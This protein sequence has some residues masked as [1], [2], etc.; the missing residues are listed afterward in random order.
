KTG[1]QILG[2]DWLLEYNTGQI[3][4]VTIESPNYNLLLHS[5]EEH[6]EFLHFLAS[7][8]TTHTAIKNGLWSDP[9]TWDKG[10]VPGSNANVLIP[11]QYK[12]I[13]DSENSVSLMTT[14]VDGALEFAADKNTKM[15][16]DTLAV[17]PTGQLTIGTASNPIQADKTAIIDFRSDT[18]ID[19]NS[20][21]DPTQL[22]KGL[23]SHGQVNIYGADKL[24]Y[25]K[26]QGN[27]L[28]G[29]QEL[30]LDLP[31]GMTTPSG[32]KVGDQLVLGGTYYDRKGADGKN[33]RFHDE[34]LTIIAIDGNR[35]RCKN[36]DIQS[37]NDQVLRFDH[38][39]TPDLSSQYN[40]KLYVANTTRNVRFESE[41]GPQTAIQR[42]GHVMLMHNPNVVVANAGFYNLGRTDKTKLIDDVEMNRD[43][44]PGGGTNIRGRYA[45]HF[46]KAGTDQNHAPIIASG[47]AIVG[48]PG[49]GISQ[50]DSNAILENNV[51]FDVAGA[52]YVAE[53]GTE[54][55]Q[56]K[57]NLAIKIT[58]QPNDPG[59]S[60]VD[61]DRAQR[62]DYGY[63]GDGYWVG[64]AGVGLNLSNNIA[65]S[66]FGA[67]LQQLNS[68]FSGTGDSDYFPVANL[69]EDLKFLGNYGYS[70][71][72]L[73]SLPMR[74]SGFEASNFRVGLSFYSL[75]ANAD[76]QVAMNE[77]FSSPASDVRSSITNFK[78][79]NIFHRGIEPFYSTR[80]DFVNGLVAANLAQ[81]SFPALSGISGNSDSL[82]HL[83]KNLRVEGFLTGIK[84]PRE[85]QKLAPISV[86][87]LGTRLEDSYL[88]NY[89]QNLFEGKEVQGGYDFSDYFK[90]SNTVFVSA[91]SNLA[92]T[93]AFTVKS[94]GS[95]AMSF[96]ASSSFDPDFWSR[97]YSQSGISP[98]SIAS[99][100]WDWN[101]DG[102]ID[103]FGRNVT[104]YFDTPGVSPVTLTVWD[105]YGKTGKITQNVNITPTAYSNL[106]VNG[107]FSL[108]TDFIRRSSQLFAQNGNLEVFSSAS[109]NYGWT[110]DSSWVRS[111]GAAVLVS[112]GNNYEQVNLQGGQRI[113]QVLAD[114]GIRRGQQTFSVDIKNIEGNAISNQINLRVWGING[115]FGWNNSGP[116]QYDA[117]PMSSTKLLDQTV[118]GSTFDWK[119]FS[120]NA[121]FGNGYQ[122][123]LVEVVPQ[124]V[125]PLSGDY[126][127]L[128]NFQ[129]LGT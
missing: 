96:D 20:S 112:N 32:W 128:Y 69:P 106:I 97:W 41:G 119:T 9:N 100:G 79:W 15:L 67:G 50:H 19:I 51:I 59:F 60:P 47:N 53:A 5:Q 129:L 90:I 45:L 99:Y 85:A 103:K 65:I 91:N 22:G 113:G 40:L 57:D 98:D 71:I 35:I 126:L 122:F 89:D 73:K 86:P 117:V 101:N 34:S 7:F 48:S 31:T 123:I 102:K 110:A 36:N 125:N 14:R 82:D 124:N 105:T 63:E 37:G 6:E 92:P 114:Y 8:N 72:P 12:V 118:G 94:S 52:A 108:G 116:Y 54:L 120:W 26:L 104:H 44:T 39:T 115:Q 88:N 28:A 17:A 11:Q 58:G 43:G 61:W 95:L 77:P 42:R 68:R 16:V 62:F 127:A 56:W 75:L 84:T 109:G 18:A 93:A 49:W 29:S 27:A 81:G 4:A 74:I 24:D 76:G 23:V 1:S 107:D 25:V 80:M 70:E 87:F 21:L 46:H 10:Q 121:D 111:N 78:L 64:G 83:Y 33:S 38:K 55:G 30:V 2:G 66:G 3:Q 13:Y